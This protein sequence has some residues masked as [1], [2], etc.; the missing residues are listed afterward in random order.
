MSCL[1]IVQHQFHLFLGANL[2]VPV[3]TKSRSLS[4]CVGK[5]AESCSLLSGP[6]VPWTG[7]G[8]FLGG[9]TVLEG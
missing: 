7:G 6:N 3:G 2:A 5:A 1:H 8:R 4:Q 9:L